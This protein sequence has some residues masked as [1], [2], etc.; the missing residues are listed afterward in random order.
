MIM[1]MGIRGRQKGARGLG[2]GD[3]AMGNGE[4]GMEGERHEVR[5]AW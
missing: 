3:W 2:N 5:M 4:W 1:V